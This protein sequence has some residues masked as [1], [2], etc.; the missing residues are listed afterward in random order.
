MTTR[1]GRARA[2]LEVLKQTAGKWSDD[3]ASRLAAALAFYAAISIAPLLLVII[4]IA[5]FAFGEDAARGAVMDQLGGFIG[6]ESA[7]TVESMVDS[8]NKP[9]T[10]MFATIVG[11]VVLLFGATGVFVELQSAMNFIWKVAPAQGL[12][13]WTFVR[14]RFL[15]LSMVLAVAFLLVVSLVVNA[16][17]TALGS[18]LAGYLP[19]APVVWGLLGQLVSFMVIALLFALIFQVLP[20][21][22]VRFRD[23]WL[24]AILTAALFQLGK[25]LVGL[26]I[27]KADVASS[28]GAAGSVIVMLLWIYYSAQIFFFGAELTQVVARM[29]GEPIQPTKGAQR[30][31]APVSGAT[32]AHPAAT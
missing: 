24:G 31:T 16:G 20:D 23:V 27:A 3:D 9:R 32:P 21:A 15:S 7:A 13:V 17:L 26:Y 6:W 12:G 10:G 5:G 18:A 2:A 19:G 30:L 8:A 28:Y 4:A 22:K 11:V 25:F 14:H 1:G 29:R